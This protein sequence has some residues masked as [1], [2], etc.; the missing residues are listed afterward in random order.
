MGKEGCAVVIDVIELI[1]E[2]V[3][4]GTVIGVG[5]SEVSKY[6]HINDYF[7]GSGEYYGGARSANDLR[8]SALYLSAVGF[9]LTAVSLILSAVV[10][11]CCQKLNIL[12]ATLFIIPMIDCVVQSAAVL[13]SFIAAGLFPIYGFNGMI[14]S[15]QNSSSL[16]DFTVSSGSITINT[17][18]ADV[19]WNR[20]QTE[21]QCCGI[22]G[23]TDYNVN[24]W[25]TNAGTWQGRSPDVLAPLTCCVQSDGTTVYPPT[26]NS[27]SASCLYN[28]TVPSDYYQPG[29]FNE[30]FSAFTTERI[31]LLVETVV[32]AAIPIIAIILK[33]VFVWCS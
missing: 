21:L 19:L 20:L 18:H 26:S 9:F 25:N 30:L 33:A 31:L 32:Q 27:L 2:L 14:L 8:Q 15:F 6:A 28:G 17:T 7:V 11:A 24:I 29:C 12:T 23:Y 10:A 22:T 16:E 1:A 3:L 13:M 5:L 4:A